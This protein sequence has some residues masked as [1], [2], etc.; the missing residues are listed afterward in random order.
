M[1]LS[2]TTVSAD[3]TAAGYLIAPT[4]VTVH[5][6]LMVAIGTTGL[7]WI[8]GLVRMTERTGANFFKPTVLSVAIVV[9]SA[10]SRVS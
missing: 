10:V 6:W 8:D 9:Q 4:Y 3:F 7:E 5:G 2:R 1:V